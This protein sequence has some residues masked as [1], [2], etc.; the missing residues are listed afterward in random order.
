ME[1][2]TAWTILPRRYC[3]CGLLDEI[4]RFQIQARIDRLQ[5][6]CD[7]LLI[8]AIIPEEARRNGTAV[9]VFDEETPVEDPGPFSVYAI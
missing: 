1:Q 9:D 5:E 3:T 6:M 7:R 2:L 4:T 8:I